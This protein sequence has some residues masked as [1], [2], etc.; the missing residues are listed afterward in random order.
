LPHAQALRSLRL[1]VGEVMPVFSETDALRAA[2]EPF[3]A[4]AKTLSSS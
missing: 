4:D 1:F 3:E 2:G